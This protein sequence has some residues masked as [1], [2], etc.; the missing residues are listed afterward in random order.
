MPTNNSHWIVKIKNWIYFYQ[1]ALCHSYGT[2]R[3]LFVVLT[4]IWQLCNY[5]GTFFLFLIIHSFNCNKGLIGLN[6]YLS[7]L[8]HCVFLLVDWCVLTVVRVLISARHRFQR[9]ISQLHR[10]RCF[11]RNKHQTLSPFCSGIRNPCSP[12]KATVCH[13]NLLD[14]VS[15]RGQIWFFVFYISGHSFSYSFSFSAIRFQRV[16]PYVLNHVDSEQCHFPS[17]EII[18]ML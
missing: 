11:C 9:T 16:C 15:V 6:C 13:S 7:C 1:S 2:P 5:S 8:Y 12:C 14:R 18:Y 17:I 3:G 4:Y 10:Y